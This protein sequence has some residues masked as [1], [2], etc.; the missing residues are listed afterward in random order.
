MKFFKRRAELIAPAGRGRFFPTLSDPS[1]NY[2]TEIPLTTTGFIVDITLPT[3]K[4][5]DVK[6]NCIGPTTF[7][8]V[9]ADDTD[10]SVNA[11]SP[12][13]PIAVSGAI[14]TNQPTLEFGY[15]A[16]VGPATLNPAAAPFI[17]AI[18]KIS[19]ERKHS[20]SVCRRRANRERRINYSRDSSMLQSN[21]G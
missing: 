13:T 2:E 18:V 10:T 21:R 5:C 4:L 15:M 17:V 9:L 20:R 14:G 12:I 6:G 11:V 3:A 19:L 8:S 16:A 1:S 7:S